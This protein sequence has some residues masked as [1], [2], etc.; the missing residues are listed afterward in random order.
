MGTTNLPIPAQPS[1]GVA[2]AVGETAASSVAARAKAEVEARAIVAIQRP[3]SVQQFRLGLLESCKRTRFA[4]TARYSKPVGGSRVE[5]FSI[6]FAEECAR[7]YG[8]LAIDAQVVYD[9]ADRRIVRVTATD[10]E[11]NNAYSL[12]VSVAKSVERR[13]VKA[14]DDVLRSRTNSTGDTVYILRAD[15][16]ALLNKQSALVSKARRQLI[17]AHIPSDITEEAGEVVLDT[18]RAEDTRDPA[19]ARKRLVDA[20]YS[21]GV[22]P[23]D[24]ASFLGH[25][26][27]KLTGAEVHFL[28]SIY[29]GIREGES[30]WADVVAAQG[31]KGTV[32][33]GNGTRS[34]T[35]K[36]GSEQ[37][38]ETLGAKVGADDAS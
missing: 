6:R 17:L 18:L 24:L 4:E 33:G 1:A 36:T 2:V 31:G 13:R 15:D 21:L 35:R 19:A 3:R 5:G 34:S 9:D 23:D 20:F 37:L 12:D 8:N 14:G 29:A 28:R 30:T 26:L 7:H 38:A 25:A 11:A 27:E 16:D 32:E 10:L 22:G